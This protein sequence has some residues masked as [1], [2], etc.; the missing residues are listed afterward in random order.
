MPALYAP[1][2]AHVNPVSPGAGEGDGDGRAAIGGG[3]DGDVTA[4]LFG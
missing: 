4:A 2:R 1:R 3:V